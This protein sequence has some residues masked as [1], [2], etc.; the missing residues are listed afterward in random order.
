[1]TTPATSSVRQVAEQLEELIEGR[2]WEWAQR[3]WAGLTNDARVKVGE[4]LKGLI[5]EK[6]MNQALG[7]KP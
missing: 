7:I 3:I 4:H 5:N 1:M 6:L 2:Q